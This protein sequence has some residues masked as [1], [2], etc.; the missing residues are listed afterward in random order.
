MVCGHRAIRRCAA[1]RRSSM[2]KL[3]RE[4]GRVVDAV[5]QGQQGLKSALYAQPLSCDARAVYALAS[6]TLGKR[7]ALEASLSRCG[8]LEGRQPKK[9][10]GTG[11][12]ATV[13]GGDASVIEASQLGTALVMTYDLLL[14]QGLRGGGQLS[15][16][17]K[18]KREAL[19]QGFKVVAGSQAAK[20]D[21][22]PAAVDGACMSQLPRY[23]RINRTKVSSGEAAAK[24]LRAQLQEALAQR[25][26]VEGKVADDQLVTTVAVDFDSLVPDVLVVPGHARALLHDQPLVNNG[27]VVLQDRSSCLAALSAGITPNSVV[28][29]ACAAPGSKTAHI[30]DMLSGTGCVIA[31]ERDPRRAVS[32]VRRL[33]DLVML[34]RAPAGKAKAGHG[35]DAGDQADAWFDTID[36]SLFQAGSVWKFRAGRGGGTRVEIHVGDFLHCRPD[37]APFKHV[38]VLLT[39]PSCSGSGLPEHHMDTEAA[40]PSSQRLRRLAAFQGRILRH[41][42]SFPGARTVVYSTCS[43]HR[44]ENEAVVAGALGDGAA[45]DFA[46][47]DALPWWR[48]SGTPPSPSWE[49]WCVRCDPA[50]D[51]CRGFFL[52][53]LDRT[54]PGDPELTEQRASASAILAQDPARQRAVRR[55][56]AKPADP[57]SELRPRARKRKRRR[58]AARASA[59]QLAGIGRDHTSSRDSVGS[60]G[61]GAGK[62]RKPA[63]GGGI[64]ITK[65]VAA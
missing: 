62:K 29:D 3:Y 24:E 65:R 4:A 13:D 6:G 43:V 15:R 38:D 14:G 10:K 33:R 55:K 58:D 56:E 34:R 40:P 1:L 32:L 21:A 9:K 44:T 46:V 26:R 49:A 42:L 36:E 25:A 7:K 54:R 18:G 60:R 22:G 16:L 37:A 39:D 2:S 45:G 63:K 19:A 41:A 11:R 30:V 52:C 48:G 53:R 50:K 51:R 61:E 23:L 20:A 8:L 17:L 28:L 35:G 59:A 64:Q 12:K 31:C 47:V 5:R 27:L 57:L